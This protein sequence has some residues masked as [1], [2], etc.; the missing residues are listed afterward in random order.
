MTA[1]VA[2]CA[3]VMDT[4]AVGAALGIVW[5]PQ[6]WSCLDMPLHILSAELTGSS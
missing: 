3:A 6:V 5:L 2:N 1:V 4:I